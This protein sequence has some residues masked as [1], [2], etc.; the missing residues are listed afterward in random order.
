MIPCQHL[1]TLFPFEYS[2]KEGGHEVIRDVEEQIEE[3]SAADVLSVSAPDKKHHRY[4]RRQKVSLILGLFVFAALVL[5][6]TPHTFVDTAIK[7]VKLDDE[8]LDEASTLGMVRDGKIIDTY[9]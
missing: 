3:G 4:S 5:I 2:S 6:P 7:L 9:S 8:L 1:Q